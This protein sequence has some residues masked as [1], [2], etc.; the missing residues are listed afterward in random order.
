[1]QST[2]SV[3]TN[4][5]NNNVLTEDQYTF[6][7]GTHRPTCINYGCNSPV[8]LSYGSV[9]DDTGYRRLRSVCSHCH[10]VSYG[11][12]DQKGT[13]LS[14]KAGV[15]PHKKSYC[16]NVDGHVTGVPC[17]A[18]VLISGQLDLDHIDGNHLNNIPENVQTLCKN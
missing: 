11:M 10:K 16:E 2:Q 18:S 6:H 8:A 3:S 4:V 1:M 15:I 7:D 9:A 13:P 5:E 14:L 17:T 12:K